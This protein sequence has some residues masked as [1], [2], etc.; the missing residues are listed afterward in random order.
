MTQEITNDLMGRTWK[1]TGVAR[2]IREAI[3][4]SVNGRSGLNVYGRDIHGKEFRIIN[5]KVHHG[6]T[7]GK[8]LDNGKWAVIYTWGER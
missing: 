8:R 5:V 3:T 7:Y 1:T 6:L 4:E 2:E